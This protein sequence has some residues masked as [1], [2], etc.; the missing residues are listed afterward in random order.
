M[1]F[2]AGT[3]NFHMMPR[4]TRNASEPQITSLPEGIS[5]FGAFWQSSTDA[6]FASF[7]AH[8]LSN[9]LA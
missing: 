7:S 2:T 9:L 3:P 4:S 1:F 6:P 8:S 5:G